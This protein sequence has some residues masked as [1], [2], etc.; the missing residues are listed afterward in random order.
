M[1]K[2]ISG[3][4]VKK[5]FDIATVTLNRWADDGKV[6]FVKG[7]GG[8]RLY[9]QNG[10]YNLFNLEFPTI[11]IT[12]PA[13]RVN[14]CYCRVSS[15]HQSEDLK[16]QIEFLSKEYPGYEIISDIGSGLNWKRKGF[17]SLLDRVY[18]NEIG[19]VVVAYKDR[20]CRFGVE[21]V[22]F[23]FKKAG[24]TFVVHSDNEVSGGENKELSDDLLA[25]VTSFVAR[26]NGRRSGINRRRRDNQKGGES[27]EDELFI[28]TTSSE[29]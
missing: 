24:T 8:R 13:E 26:A 21:L 17:I 19:K 22:Q 10:I 28:E 16:R 14:V 7:P 29:V 18:K 9:S 5:Q 3:T 2:F 23:I 1:D 4:T 25:V 6:K 20:L 11:P 12:E 27:S 15:A